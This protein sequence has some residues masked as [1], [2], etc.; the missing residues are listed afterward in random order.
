MID[1]RPASPAHV[2]RIARNMREADTLECGAFGRT[3]RQALRFGLQASVLAFTAFDERPVAMLGLTPVNAIESVARPWLLGTDAVFAC[4]RPLLTLGPPIIA[5]MHARFRR[6]ENQV[7]TG[8]TRAI[9]LLGQWGF[10]IGD[11]VAMIGGLP[12]VDFWREA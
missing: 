7:W 12:F 8:N 9:R 1:L 11:E 6:L 4:A 3:P 5:A 2:G 10:E